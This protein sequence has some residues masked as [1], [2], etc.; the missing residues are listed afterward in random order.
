MAKR[1]VHVEIN[2]YRIPSADLRG[3][4]VEVANLQMARTLINSA[5]TLTPIFPM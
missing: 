5:T 1:A 3:C 2:Q 4:V